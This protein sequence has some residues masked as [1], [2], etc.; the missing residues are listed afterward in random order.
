MSVTEQELHLGIS[1]ALASFQRDYPWPLGEG[2]VE[3]VAGRGCNLAGDGNTVWFTTDQDLLFR[4]GCGVLLTHYKGTA[5]ADQIEG[6]LNSLKALGALMSGVP[7]DL[8]RVVADAGETLPLL[9]W[10]R[11]A[12]K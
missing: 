4:I 2:E 1:V 10:W 9:A 5:V 11:G 12:A 8:E 6:T 3:E 7:V